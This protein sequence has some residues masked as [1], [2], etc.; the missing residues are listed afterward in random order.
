M[1]SAC[2]T[3]ICMPCKCWGKVNPLQTTCWD[4]LACAR[5]V[6]SFIVEREVEAP[7][8][9]QAIQSYRATMAVLRHQRIFIKQL[10]DSGVVED[11]ER[12]ELS[13]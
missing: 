13:R 2:A 5:Q 12:D 10:F 3:C 6:W 11:S 8:R 1:P 9:F 7:E 4:A